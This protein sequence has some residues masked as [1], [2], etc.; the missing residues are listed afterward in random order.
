MGLEPMGQPPGREMRAFPI[1]A[2]KGAAKRK[3]PRNLLMDSYGVTQ[4][5][6]SEKSTI[7]FPWE[8][9]QLPPSSVSTD[10]IFVM[11]VRLGILYNVVFPQVKIVAARIGR[12][13]FFE[14]D[15]FTSPDR[16]RDFFT[17]IFDIFQIL[18]KKHLLLYRFYVI[19]NS[20]EENS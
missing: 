17:I 14:P 6:Q 1:R 8:K 5:L 12:A 2:S 11:S 20:Q 13:A 16:C 3:D 4:L 18:V 10:S 19:M 7:I 15:A 9:V